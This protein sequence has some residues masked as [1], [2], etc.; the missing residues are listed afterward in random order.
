MAAKIRTP[1]FPF[2]ARFFELLVE[3]I[4]AAEKMS[5]LT[6]G[7]SKKI[8]ALDLV[9]KWYRDFGLYLPYVPR[10]IE[11]RVVRKIASDLIDAVVAFLK[12]SRIEPIR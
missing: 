1:R 5:Q 3:V 4:D 8:Y 11:R 12:S 9:D 7:R 6:D 10:A 2:W